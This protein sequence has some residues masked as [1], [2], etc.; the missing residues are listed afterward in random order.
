MA[1]A[2]KANEPWPDG[3]DGAATHAAAVAQPKDRAG[4]PKAPPPL[5]PCCPEAGARSLPTLV[6]GRVVAGQPDATFAQSEASGGKAFDGKAD[7]HAGEDGEVEG[8]EDGENDEGPA[9]EP[10]WAAAP[11]AS[12][13]EAYPI[14]NG[15]LGALVRWLDFFFF[16]ARSLRHPQSKPF[17]YSIAFA[18]GGR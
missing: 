14:G 9:A 13:A 1:A 8:E 3:G 16:T 10:L 15:I 18:K 5:V 17:F 12:W 11:A 2:A 4:K 6:G 7:Q